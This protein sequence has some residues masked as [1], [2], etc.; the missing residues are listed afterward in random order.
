[1]HVSEVP[2]R[3]VV[4]ASIGLKWVLQETHSREAFMLAGGRELLTTALFWAEA[5]NAIASRVRRG[6]LELQRGS[7]AFR[8]LRAVPLR[9]QA[10]D[11]ASVETALTI[12]NELR[13][14]IYDCCYLALAIAENAPVV[15]ADRRFG[16]AVSRLPRL[17]AS[18]VVIND[19]TF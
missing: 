2:A 7:D 18:V 6:D 19:I 17:A 9:I 15:T 13:H 8:E 3:I 11:A 10:L 16:A 4:D 5:G 14:P 1:M 12:A